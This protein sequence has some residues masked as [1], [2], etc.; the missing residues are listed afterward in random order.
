MQV[1][2]MYSEQKTHQKT[3]FLKMYILSFSE[4]PPSAFSKNLE[5]KKG[6]TSV[7]CLKTEI[8]RC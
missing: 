7:Q 2:L 1:F 4:Q 3:S 6:S 8:F 5:Q